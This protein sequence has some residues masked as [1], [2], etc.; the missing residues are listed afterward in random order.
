[1][2]RSRSSV[3]VCTPGSLFLSW[4]NAACW[5]R[6][7][8]AWSVRRPAA[9]TIHTRSALINCAWAFMSIAS[10]MAP[11]RSIRR[12]ITS[13]SP[14]RWVE[15]ADGTSMPRAHTKGRTFLMFSL[16]IGGQSVGRTVATECSGRT[17]PDATLR[18]PRD[19]HRHIAVQPR[20]VAQLCEAVI[21]PAVGCTVHSDA[22][23]VGATVAGAD[24][25]EGQSARDRHRTHVTGGGPVAELARGI[26]APAVG[27]ARGGDPAG[28]RYAGAHCGEGEPAQ[29]RHWARPRGCGTIAE[30]SEGVVAPAVGRACS[31]YAAGVITSA[32]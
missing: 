6:M 16:H 24:D 26:A 20:A 14:C 32:A 1:M 8:V 3:N 21:P 18:L 7:F 25:G 15:A 31:V 30:V 2:S 17:R 13:S 19:L 5:I 29:H 12:L 10:S 23:R 27:G 4:S 22:A 9:C 28:V 11:Y